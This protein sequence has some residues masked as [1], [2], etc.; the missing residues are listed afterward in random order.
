M[1]NE[2]RGTITVQNKNDQMGTFDVVVSN[3][4]SSSGLTEVLVPVWS[5]AG[6]Q[7]DLKWYVATRQSD[8]SFRASVKASDHKYS[9]G[10]Y[11]IHLYY[12][13]SDNSLRAIAGTQ[14]TVTISQEK[15]TANLSIVNINH[16]AGTF[17]VLV[18]NITSYYGVKSVEVPVWSETGGQDDIKWYTA[19]QQADGS[20]KLTVKASNHKNDGGL[21]HAHLYLTQGNGVGSSLI[22][23][24][25]LEL[26]YQATRSKTIFIDPGHGGTDPGAVYGGVYEKTLALSVANLL[27]AK[28]QANGYTVIMSRLGD[29]SVGFATERSILANN[30]N[31]DLFVSLHFNATGNGT[32]TASGIETYWYQY[33][34]QYPP[35][36]NGAMHNDSTR[37]AESE[38]LANTVQQNLV[39]ATGATNRGVKRATYAVLRETAIPAILVE[40][41]FMDNPSELAKVTRGDYQEKLATGLANGIFAWYGAVGGK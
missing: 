27:K 35:A 36:I 21:Y 34:A 2:M 5:E 11:A 4:Q 19:Y 37:L 20:Y 9:T 10:Q 22:A 41:G 23:T 31:A 16:Q 32:T 6:G 29:Q 17:D 39:T 3:V 1:P 40:M 24:S 30:S 26:N 15:P 28:L 33:Y 7:D 12:R 14:T 25:T 8:G 18:T 38:I 13:V